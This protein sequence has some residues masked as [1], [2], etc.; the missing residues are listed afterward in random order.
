MALKRTGSQTLGPFFNYALR[1]EGDNDLTRRSPSGPQADGEIVTLR[2]RV[3]D[4]ASAP[5]QNVLVEIWQ[6]DAKG[7]H[8]DM[9]DSDANFTGFGRTLTDDDGWYEFTTVI[10]GAVPG[11]GN[12][13]QAPHISLSLFSSGLLKRVTTRVYFPDEDANKDDPVLSGIANETVR[14]TLIAREVA[15]GP[16]RSISFDVILQGEGETA[17][18]DL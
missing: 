17:F 8:T 15:P 5:C 12:A 6:A 18:F 4:G 10:P 2:G 3:T 14:S 11:K 13:W 1:R 16:P 9:D 7:H